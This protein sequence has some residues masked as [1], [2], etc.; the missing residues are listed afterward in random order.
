MSGRG[1]RVVED[2]TPG[3]LWARL[4]AGRVTEVYALSYSGLYHDLPQTLGLE[5]IMPEPYVYGR[6]GVLR[7]PAERAEVARAL[8][9]EPRWL[10][11]GGLPFWAE[12]FARRAEAILIFPG[13]LR[14]FAGGWRLAPGRRWMRA[15]FA[16]V[17]AQELADESSAAV[18]RMYGLDRTLTND[19]L[20]AYASVMREFLLAEFPRKT[21]EIGRGEAH[22][23]LRAVRAARAVR[24][25]PADRPDAPVDVSRRDGDGRR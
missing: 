9:A 4:L 19:E 5:V 8:A 3:D 24:A 17:D 10:A 20:W 14:G 2:D 6:Y 11:A 25:S 1:G 7:T 13:P 22:A 21:I 16:P 23:Q 12:H 18:Q 15:L